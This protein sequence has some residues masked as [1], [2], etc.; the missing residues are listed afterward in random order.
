MLPRTSGCLST[1]SIERQ[2][3]ILT[4]QRPTSFLK[5]TVERCEKVI[6]A[7]RKVTLN[8][9]SRRPRGT[10]HPCKLTRAIEIVVPLPQTFTT[11]RT[12]PM[13]FHPLR[14]DQSLFNLDTVSA[15]QPVVQTIL[16][17]WS[18]LATLGTVVLPAFTV[19]TLQKPSKLFIISK[20]KWILAGRMN[21]FQKL[22]SALQLF[23]SF[24]STTQ[25]RTKLWLV[26]ATILWVVLSRMM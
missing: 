13:A 25:L 22:N 10:L 3:L 16:E 17:F 20:P 8:S 12:M 7:I 26:R 21:R 1:R 18:A 9:C 19:P 5:A 15:F 4:F 23:T 2:H 24:K 6:M 11:A 14:R